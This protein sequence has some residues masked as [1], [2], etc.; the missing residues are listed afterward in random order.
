MSLS[1]VP[2][3]FP[4]MYT[5]S[6]LFLSDPSSLASISTA[7]STRLWGSPKGPA[8]SRGHGGFLPGSQS[9]LT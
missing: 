3:D 6:S 4:H 8:F 9:G 7:L 2:R 1:P 5:P